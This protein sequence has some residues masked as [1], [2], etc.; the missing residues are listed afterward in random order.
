MRTG[1]L[2][3]ADSDGFFF[4][5][6]RLKRFAKMFGR[7]INLEDI[8]RDLEVRYSIRAAAVD[9]EGQLVIYAAAAED[10]MDRTVIA[11]YLAQTL[12]VPPKYITVDTIAEIPMTASGKKDYRALSS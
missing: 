3:T 10:Q 2:A 1:D 12:S 11:R 8:E 6:G 4:L 9:R 5:T 7:R